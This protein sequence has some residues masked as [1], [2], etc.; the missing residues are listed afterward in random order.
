MAQFTSFELNIS[1]SELQRLRREGKLELGL[2]ERPFADG[3]CDGELPYPGWWLWGRVAILLAGIY[4]TFA[5]AWWWSIVTVALL[6]AMASEVARGIRAALVR[7]AEADADL[8][9]RLSL[10][11][12]WIYKMDA[13]DAE[14]YRRAI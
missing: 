5:S 8:Y 10:E 13:G 14:Q 11:G 3:M 9:D 4:L 12:A 7:A 1:H 2:N 6:M